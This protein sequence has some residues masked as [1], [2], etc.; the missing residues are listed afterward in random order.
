M[1]KIE[2]PN[3]W[4]KSGKLPR[5]CLSPEHEPPM[6]IYLRPGDVLVHKCP[7]CGQVRRI[8]APQISYLAAGN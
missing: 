2:R 6:H 5:P 8:M 4:I 3:T 7:A 1:T